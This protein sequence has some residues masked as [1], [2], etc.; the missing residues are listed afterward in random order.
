MKRT[1]ENRCCEVCDKFLGRDG[2][3]CY[4]NLLW[5][6]EKWHCQSCWSKVMAKQN[7]G[8]QSTETTLITS[9]TDEGKK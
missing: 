6:L 1:A 8:I 5:G 9:L 7:A 3:E 4:R 2:G